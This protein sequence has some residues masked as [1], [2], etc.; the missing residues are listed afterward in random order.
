MATPSFL[1]K[2]PPHQVLAWVLQVLQHSARNAPAL[3]LT[4]TLAKP[5]PNDTQASQGLPLG[6]LGSSGSLAFLDPEWVVLCQTLGAKVQRATS[7]VP[8]RWVSVPFGGAHRT[9]CACRA[10]AVR[11]VGHIW[12][13]LC[14]KGVPVDY[15]VNCCKTV[16]LCKTKA[17]TRFLNLKIGGYRAYTPWGTLLLALVG[18]V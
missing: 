1:P 4:A 6:S 3:A 9:P 16:E 7:D 8:R 5:G 12:Y 14:Q 13:G 2:E 18:Q 11:M 10:R 15:I 17:K